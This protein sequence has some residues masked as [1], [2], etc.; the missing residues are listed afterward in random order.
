[1]KVAQT[2]RALSQQDRLRWLVIGTAIIVG[3]YGLLV[4]PFTAK[5]LTRS[6]ALLARRIDRIE[7]RAQVPQVDAAAAATLQGRFAKL[8]KEREALEA[9]HRELAGGFAPDHDAAAQQSLV[10]EL[11]TL[12]KASGIRLTKQGD[13]VAGGR[14]GSAAVVQLRDRESGRPY[15]RLQGVGDY[16]SLLAFLGGLRGLGYASAPL[17]LEIQPIADP[18]GRDVLLDIRV[19]VT[20]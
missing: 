17:G 7:R 14:G 6:S 8:D 19:D 20:L 15:M 5:E 10:L 16:W 3:L 4:Y 2:W 11:N 18:K 13:E 1:M 9:R 12:A